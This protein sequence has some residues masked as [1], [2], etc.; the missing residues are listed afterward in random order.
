MSNAEAA[1]VIFEKKT[2]EQEVDL[3]TENSRKASEIV[4]L[5]KEMEA[6]KGDLKKIREEARQ[7]A[8]QLGKLQIN[9]RLVTVNMYLI[10]IIYLLVDL[11]RTISRLE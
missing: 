2:K 9:K 3:K 7:Q 11:R 10:L 6:A 5:T 4:T 8:E 1:R